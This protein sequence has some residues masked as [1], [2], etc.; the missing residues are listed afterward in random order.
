MEARGFFIRKKGSDGYQFGF[1]PKLKKVVNDRKASLHE[2]EVFAE[3]LKIVG[4]EFSRG[5]VLPVIPFPEDG[6]AVQDTTKLSLVVLSPALEWTEDG[7]LRKTILDW[8]RNRGSSPRLYPGSLIWCIRKPGRELRNKV[9]ILLAWRNVNREYMDGTLPGEFD[10]SDYEE[11]KARLKDAQ[12]AAQ[13]EVW[14]GYR[15]IALYD[16]KSENGITVIDLGAGHANAG[17]TCYGSG[18]H[19]A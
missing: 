13:D 8:T 3:T 11:I 18:H 19:D 10:K 16:S 4:E 7:S 5:K 12:D 6:A 9:E 15:Y 2:D 14:A 17:E 1:K